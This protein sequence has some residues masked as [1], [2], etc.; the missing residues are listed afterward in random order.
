MIESRVGAMQESLRA[1]L[2]A[3]GIPQVGPF[4]TADEISAAGIEGLA[5]IH[6]VHDEEAIRRL[7]AVQETAQRWTTTLRTRSRTL[8]EFF[9][10]SRRL[11]CG[12]CVGLG[13][14]KL[15]LTEKTYD[16]V[17]IDEAARATSSEL[18]VACNQ[19][20]GYCSSATTSSCLPRL[21]KRL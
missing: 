8:E 1:Q 4:S 2:N 16:L 5:R 9:A 14:P 11:V 3:F 20:I 21:R 13:S 18:A 19:P 15:R 17:V 7:C 6:T 12:T 10:G